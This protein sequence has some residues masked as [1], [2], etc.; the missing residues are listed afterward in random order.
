MKSLIS[1]LSI[2]A[3][4]SCTNNTNNTNETDWQKANL[5]GKA[6]LVH[7]TTFLA[8]K[9]FGEISKVS[10]L[11]KDVNHYNKQGYLIERDYYDSINILLGKTIYKYTQ[12]NKLIE[13]REYD[14]SGKLTLRKAYQFNSDGSVNHILLRNE[15][16]VIIGSLDY[17]YSVEKD[18]RVV[19]ISKYENDNLTET[20][21]NVYDKNNLLKLE[22]FYDSEGYLMHTFYYYYNNEKLTSGLF[23]LY[24]RETNTK[25]KFA[26]YY[27]Y[28]E[29]DS[30][31][32]WVS[33]RIKIDY[34]DSNNQDYTITE[35]E[36]EYY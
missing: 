3:I 15:E 4:V 16:D 9:K 25:H 20:S 21:L 12:T 14:E 8:A 11:S 36:I 34:I 35:R 33:K 28:Y 26:N 1:L 5:K 19:G 6:K 7:E 18:N 13:E 22:I 29:Y 17:H 2:I 32:S 31:G 10:F 24:S 30:K 23:E 27:Y